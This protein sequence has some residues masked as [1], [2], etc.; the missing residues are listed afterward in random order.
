MYTRNNY[1]FTSLKFSACVYTRKGLTNL[2]I[3]IGQRSNM[4][5]LIKLL[6]SRLQT[7]LKLSCFLLFTTLTKQDENNKNCYTDRF[8]NLEQ[9]AFQ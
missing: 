9:I 1:N 4:Q 7:Y 5:N 3:L 2:T 8:Q 6:F